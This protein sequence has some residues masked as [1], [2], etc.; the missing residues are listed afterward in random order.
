MRHLTILFAFILFCPFHTTGQKSVRLNKD[1][2]IDTIYVSFK[3]TDT[4]DDKL[5]NEL[6]NKFDSIITDFNAQQDKSFKLVI[7]SSYSTNTIK[8]VMGEIQYVNSKKRLLTA[9]IDIVCL[10][11]DMLISPFPPIF[12][13]YLSPC[14]FCK[15]D[16]IA[17]PDLINK[18][19]K[20][21]VNPDGSFA[22]KETQKKKFKKNFNKRFT[23]F[24]NE[25]DKQYKKNNK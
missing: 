15:V 13:F 14:V 17:T 8:F 4:I 10:I 18:N 23:K 9:G 1:C 19:G 2:K 16:I 7:D 20:L 24:F 3:Q 12:P 6:Q 5:A 25:I 11:I 21:F 22:K